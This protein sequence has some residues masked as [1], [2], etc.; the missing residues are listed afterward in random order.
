MG[1]ALHELASVAKNAISRNLGPII[2]QNSVHVI[3]F[4]CVKVQVDWVDGVSARPMFDDDP[5][6]GG[7]GKRPCCLCIL[8][9]RDVASIG[10]WRD[11]F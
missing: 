2:L 3:F 9:L 5:C 8:Y 7:H 1:H 6:R 11:L 4:K 10:V